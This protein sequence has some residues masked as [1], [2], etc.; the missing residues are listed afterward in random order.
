MVSRHALSVSFSLVLLGMTASVGRAQVAVR[1]ITRSGLEVFAGGS[2]LVPPNTD[3]TSGR[4]VTA[5]GNFSNGS[6]TAT[7]SFSLGQDD[8]RIEVVLDEQASA[9][10]N[11]QP[12]L[13]YPNAYIGRNFGQHDIDVELS[14]TTPMYVRVTVTAC[15]SGSQPGYSG[16]LTIPGQGTVT[17]NFFAMC[18]APATGTFDLVLGAVPTVLVFR[19]GGYVQTGR[20]VF[21]ADFRGQWNVTVTNRSPCD[22]TRY[23]TPCGATLSSFGTLSLPGTWIELIDAARPDAAVL[24]IGSQR[25]RVPIFGCFLYTDFPIIL[26]FGLT[27]PDR[28]LVYLPPLPFAVQV[29]TQGVTIG[30]AGLRA[31]NGLELQCR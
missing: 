1:A 11:G 6:S 15:T 21:S 18:N 13:A 17:N 5:S 29:T 22:G 9:T 8:R 27:A 10:W 25:L 28:A 31:S 2:Q 16:T 23:D 24:L 20:F 26:P 14:S 12:S 4:V 19:T 3:I 30:N 7:T